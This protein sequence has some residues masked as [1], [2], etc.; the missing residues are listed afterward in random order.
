MRAIGVLVDRTVLYRGV[1]GRRTKEQISLYREIALQEQIDLILF[2][3]EQ[4]DVRRHRTYGFVPTAS[5]WR[6]VSL[7]VPRVVHKRV[8]YQSS[9]P[10]KKLHRLQRRGTVF[11]NPFLMN[12]KLSMYDLLSNDDA[13]KPH[14]PLTETYSWRRLTRH[15]DAGSS[16]IAKPQVGSVGGGILRLVPASQRRVDVTRRT[17]R[18]VS[19]RRLK[20]IMARYVDAG[21]YLLQQHLPLARYEDAPV[22][23]RVPVQKD[24]SGAWRIAGMVAKVAH[25]HA[26]LTNY[27]RGGRVFPAEAVIE[28]IFPTPLN[29]LVLEDVKQLALNVA[30]VMEAHQ[31][32]ATDLGLDVGVDVHGKAWLIEVNAR[33]QRITFAEAGL[34]EAF[35][36]LYRNP[37]AYCAALAQTLG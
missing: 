11:V 25:G 35:K 29:E 1:T 14:L 7:P 37:I 2:S 23:L 30:R 18:R 12:N 19:R 33:D 27:G 15:L 16:L 21:R 13:L 17:T 36:A 31:P 20:R 34:K 5:G 32:Y 4:V 26:F 9:A 28:Q 24:A 3:V 22:D 8:L 10:I 6:R